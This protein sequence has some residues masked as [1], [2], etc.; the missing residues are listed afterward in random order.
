MSDS[1]PVRRT[2]A[3]G[4]NASPLVEKGKRGWRRFSTGSLGINTTSAFESF[5]IIRLHANELIRT[6]RRSNGETR[7]R[8]QLF[9]RRASAACMASNAEMADHNA[10]CALQPNREFVF[11]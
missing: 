7:S 1:R 6:W 10:S 4:A 11:I 3:C 9:P 5:S 8:P 2:L